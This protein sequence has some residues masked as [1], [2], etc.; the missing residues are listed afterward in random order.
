[1]EARGLIRTMIL[2]MQEPPSYVYVQYIR[3]YTYISIY[4]YF[5]LNFYGGCLIQSESDYCHLPRI[6]G[7]LGITTHSYVGCTLLDTP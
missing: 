3:V 5:T 6:R 1:M 7:A 2:N 4:R